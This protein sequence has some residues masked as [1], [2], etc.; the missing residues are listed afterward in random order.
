MDG[1]GLTKCAVTGSK[2]SP[3]PLSWTMDG[4][5]LTANL[6][7]A[8]SGVKTTNPRAKEP[9]TGMSVCLFQSINLCFPFQMTLGRD[10]KDSHKDCFDGFFAFFNG[11]D[12]V[13]SRFGPLEPSN[14]KVNSPQDLASDW[15]TTGLGGGSASARCPCVS[16]MCHKEDLG[17]FKTGSN[18]CSHCT[19]LELERCHCHDF[20]DMAPWRLDKLSSKL[21]KCVDQAMDEGHRTLDSALA[22]SN[23]ICDPAIANKEPNKVHIDFHPCNR[24]GR[25]QFNALTRDESQLRFDT[26]DIEGFNAL[27]TQPLQVRKE[28]LKE[29][30]EEELCV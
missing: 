2:E 10:C 16:C 6:C 20:H 12:I 24:E 30:P 28:F 7:Q 1:H 13:P 23:V 8:V 22:K 21:E 11:G 25:K 27:M 9:T 14:F 26:N 18:R 5:Q 19:R 3:I 29:L 17:S 15:K 4:Q